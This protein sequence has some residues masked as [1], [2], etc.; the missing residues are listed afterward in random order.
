MKKQ[1]IIICNYH[2]TKEGKIHAC[3]NYNSNCIRCCYSKLPH[4]AKVN[5]QNKNIENLQ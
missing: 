5:R 2:G 4:K 1:E 3:N